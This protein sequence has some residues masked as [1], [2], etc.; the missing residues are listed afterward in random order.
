MDPCEPDQRDK[1]HKLETILLMMP[2][3]LEFDPV[4]PWQSALEKAYDAINYDDSTSLP[5]KETDFL[6]RGDAVVAM[7]EYV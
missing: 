6:V 3:A 5:E 1:P 2:I 4:V 7:V